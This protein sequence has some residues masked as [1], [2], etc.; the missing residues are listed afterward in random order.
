MFNCNGLVV[1]QLVK[2]KS[3]L[4]EN[5]HKNFSFVENVRF[6]NSKTLFWEK[7]YFRIIANL[8]RYRYKIPISF[9]MEKLE[10][11]LI[12]IIKIVDGKKESGLFRC[13]FIKAYEETKFIISFTDSNPIEINTSHYEM[14]LYKD[15]LVFSNDLS[16]MS[17]TNSDLRL[18]SSMY[19]NENGLNDVVLL[20]DQKKITETLNGNIFLI[21]SNQIQTPNLL[22][23]CQNLVLREVFLEWLTKNVKHYNVIEKEIN[24]FE[25]QKSDEIFII[26]L[27]KG[28]QCVSNY[29]KSSY[30]NN[31]SYPILKEFVLYLS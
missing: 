19:A 17:K 20:N 21:E 4:I 11:E 18:I 9:T 14:D 22:S 8:R 12:K 25:L 1:S 10:E 24:P 3:D 15:I 30:L 13:Q 26:S 29:R 6:Y 5:L 28:L 16:N 31:K 2:A 7:H 23:G 27:E